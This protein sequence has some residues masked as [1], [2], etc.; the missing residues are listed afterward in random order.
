MQNTYIQSLE[1]QA[2]MRGLKISFTVLRPGFVATELL[3]DDP[4]Y[5]VLLTPEKVAREMVR[6]I[7]HRR[8]VWVIDWRWRIIT[9]MWRRIPRCLWRH[10]KVR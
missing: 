1:Q 4:K 5:P 6:A 10:L 8:H 3:G 2:N 7:K 9:A